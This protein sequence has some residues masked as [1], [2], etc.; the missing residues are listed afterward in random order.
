MKRIVLV[1]ALLAAPL[2]GQAV[3]SSQMKLKTNG[4][5][6][7]D[8]ASALAVAPYRGSSAPSSPVTGQLWCDTTTTP[9]V[10]K[11][12]D[13]STWVQPLSVGVPTQ[14]D[15]GT[16]PAS[17]SDGQ[18]FFSK[19]PYA[20]FI[21]DGTAG[22]WV[23]TPWPMTPTGASII[24]T[25]SATAITDPGAS[26]ATIAS[27]A[28]AGSTG[29]G[30]YSYKI[31][32]Y[33]SSGGETLPSVVTNSV[34]PGASKSIDLSSIPTGGTGTVG[35]RIYR[36]KSG[37]NGS[38][39][40]YYLTSIADN[41]TTTYHDGAADSTL[42]AYAPTINYSAALPG[43]W[44]VQ[45]GASYAGG[46]GCGITTRN[47]LA[48]YATLMQSLPTTTDNAVARL[49]LDITTYASGNY[50][51]QYRVYQA[52]QMGDANLGIVSPVIVGLRNGTADN[53]IRW[54]EALGGCG[55]GCGG[56]GT[57]ITM[58]ISS[59]N[60]PNRSA[61]LRS[62]VGGSSGFS[63]IGINPWPQVD[64]LPIWIRVVKRGAY[65]NVYWSSDG[66][67]WAPGVNCTSA[68][69]TSSVCA[70]N[71]ALGAGTTQFEIAYAYSFYNIAQTAGSWIEIDNFTLTVN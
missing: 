71:N 5:L 41:S 14:A 64:S 59:S 15:P 65:I 18:M 49:A 48:C 54:A 7:G 35:R 68:N 8:T 61:Q 12:Y 60:H 67:Q 52:S 20:L 70:L 1:F 29:A 23:T 56:G 9:C 17:P 37:Q 10:M 13:G 33:S 31:T 11:T 16:L 6:T 42:I 19:N 50:T 57:L 51:I 36:C 58:P 44:T 53:A 21:Y 22:K 28:T 63:L 39:P 46:G 32:Y 40:W 25:Y 26:T 24:D 3:D 45:L 38:G 4:G 62:T 66:V 47:T 30:G 55:A 27:S 69:N 43:A 2:L 34:T